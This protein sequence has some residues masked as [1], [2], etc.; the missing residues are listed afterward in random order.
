[1]HSVLVLSPTH[2]CVMLHSKPTDGVNAEKAR[3]Y[4]SEAPEGSTQ[5]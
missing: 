5:G 4:L 3:A 2:I 1:M